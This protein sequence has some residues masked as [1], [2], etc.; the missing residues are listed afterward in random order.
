MV[1]D[2]MHILDLSLYNFRNYAQQTLRLSRGVNIFVGENGQGK[3]NL[4]EAV[5]YLAFGNT[6]RGNKEMELINWQQ[7]YFR[8][9][10]QL[11]KDTSSRLFELEIY[12]DRQRN[13]QIKINGVKYKRNSALLGYLQVV[14]FSPEDL[15]IVKGSPTDRRRY[16]DREICQLDGRY[17]T[18][19]HQYQKVLQQRNN[20]LKAIHYKKIAKDQ[21]IVW[22]KQLVNFGSQIISQRLA[23]LKILVPIARRLQKQL[24]DGQENLNVTYQS[25]LGAIGK[26]SQEEIAGLYEQILKENESLEINRGVTLWGPHR[27]D[28]IFYFNDRELKIYGSQGQQRT[29][30]LALK[31]AELETFY[32]H[33]G[34]YPLLLLDDVMS[35]LDD[36][37]R[38]FLLQTIDKQQIQTIITGANLD[39]LSEKIAHNEIFIVKEGKII[40]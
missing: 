18:L 3:T 16:I 33:N 20:L 21:L 15:K 10:A 11:K 28:L 9:M 12:S 32:H 39:L 38:Q 17:Y 26:L 36:S 14:L 24:T 13:K 4:L 8:V 34:E 2:M 31:L 5:Y 23:F 29:N 19:L 1:G 7:D 22:N 40:N 25:S 35:E 27:D 37:R 30:I 6:F